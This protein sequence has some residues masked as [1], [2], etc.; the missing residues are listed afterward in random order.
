MAF[1]S[2]LYLSQIRPMSRLIYLICKIIG[3]ISWVFCQI[4]VAR[5]LLRDLFLSLGCCS[6]FCLSARFTL[7]AMLSFI[8]L[9]VTLLEDV[10]LRGYRLSTLCVAFYLSFGKQ[11][12]LSFCAGERRCIW[13]SGDLKH[14]LINMNA[15]FIWLKR[16]SLETAISSNCFFFDWTCAIVSLYSEDCKVHS[17]SVFSNIYKCDKWM[18]VFLVLKMSLLLIQK[19][20]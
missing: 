18:D 17:I 15:T 14:P 1:R 10:E 5:F 4:V 12:K 7:F 3:S 16:W 19:Q 20:K 9:C 6:S 2:V 11:I 8:S 13:R